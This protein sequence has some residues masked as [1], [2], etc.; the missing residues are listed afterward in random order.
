MA[1]VHLARLT[2]RSK[3]QVRMRVGQ[4][5]LSF[6]LC[7]IDMSGL[8]SRDIKLPLHSW[9]NKFARR[10]NKFY[11]I[12]DRTVI[13]ELR[14]DGT[15]DHDRP[16]IQLQD[17]RD[18][19]TLTE[20]FIQSQRNGNLD[21]STIFDFCILKD[22]LGLADIRILQ[23]RHQDTAVWIGTPPESRART[24]IVLLD[25]RYDPNG[26]TSASRV[27]DCEEYLERPPVGK[28]VF[29]TALELP[30]FCSR[31]RRKRIPQPPQ[32][33]GAERRTIY[34][35]NPSS[36]S[37]LALAATV[38]PAN[39]TVLRDFLDRHVASRAYFG[40]STAS[41]FMPQF[42]LEFHIPFFSLRR[43][44]GLKDSRL[45]N[46]QPFRK[47]RSLPLPRSQKKDEE[48]D[49]FHEAQVSMLLY[50]IDEWVW[51]AYCC[52]DTY[53]GSEPGHRTYHEGSEDDS[54]MSYGVDAPSGGSRELRFPTWNPREYFLMV[55][56]RRMMQATREWT[57]LVHVFEER[58]IHYEETANEDESGMKF[59]FV[60]DR[61]LS[62]TK[63]LTWA[64]S[65]LQHFRDSLA[66]T[67]VAWD[68]FA[69]AELDQFN[70]GSG[71]ALQSL[72][73]GYIAEIRGHISSLRSLQLVLTQKLELFKEMKNGLTN[74]SSLRESAAATRQNETI[75][76]LTR[77]TVLYLPA[78]L[79]SSVFSIAMVSSETPWWAY[80][81]VLI[82]TTAV[83]LF[84]A[85]KP[86]VLDH[87]FRIDD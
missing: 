57:N 55:L 37:M 85:S 72:W 43:G 40:A 83:T 75:G 27:W 12:Q 44:R 78:S 20:A 17:L 35:A 70:L 64:V 47:S 74:A 82:A 54:G 56:A 22:F 81:I 42:V 13:D 2:I 65:T 63:Q 15:F 86:R 7:S 77:M 76:V 8:S 50:G 73:W 53:F 61:F 32:G 4:A 23:Q 30:E 69:S 79:A 58:L 46:G 28:N 1:S 14:A 67:L 19:S 34:V 25:D 60:D 26:G 51:T 31:L 68:N 52:V 18:A 9:E 16:R 71:E 84:A 48:Q 59:P 11:R 10:Q 6:L 80:I 45:L 87:V 29:V 36:N 49:F 38:A 62:K 24:D 66:R 39:A 3:V 41:A 33:C 21:P 5:F